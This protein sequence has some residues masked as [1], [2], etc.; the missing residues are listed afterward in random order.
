[1]AVFEDPQPKPRWRRVLAIALGLAS[2]ASI[3]VVLH[4][5]DRD[6]YYHL[7]GRTIHGEH[8]FHYVLWSWMMT[9]PFFLLAVVEAAEE[10]EFVLAFPVIFAH[11]CICIG[12]L[13]AVY[14]SYVV[15]GR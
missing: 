11:V 9:F 15:L 6:S 13:A 14:L 8:L 12:A 5:I 1:M 10:D 3:E 2:L 7:L 4:S